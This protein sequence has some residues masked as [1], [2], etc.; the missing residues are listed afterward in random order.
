MFE[1]SVRICEDEIS[2]QEFCDL[3]DGNTRN[4]RQISAEKPRRR[5]PG[6]V[7]SSMK[8]ILRREDA[9]MKLAQQA[10]ILSWLNVR[11]ALPLH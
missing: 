9:R 8:Q 2:E 4:T 5:K 11:F 3:V 1:I 10:F 7:E 6:R